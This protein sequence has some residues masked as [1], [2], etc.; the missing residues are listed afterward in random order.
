M[1]NARNPI[2]DEIFRKDDDMSPFWC[3]IYG[4]EE[5]SSRS[6]IW[7]GFDVLQFKELK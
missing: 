6:I 5:R 3:R 4:D 1:N 7:S 2:F